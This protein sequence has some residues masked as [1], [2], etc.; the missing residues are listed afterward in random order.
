[1]T[2]V[3]LLFRIGVARASVLIASDNSQGRPPRVS[4]LGTVSLGFA[5]Q[6]AKQYFGKKFSKVAQLNGNIDQDVCF[7]FKAST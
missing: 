7:W 6:R 5:A 3:L 1:M 2:L 4:I